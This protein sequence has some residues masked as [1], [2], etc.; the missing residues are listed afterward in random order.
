M[1]ANYV[2]LNTALMASM[3]VVG[4]GL[5][6]S[7]KILYAV[8]PD[9]TILITVIYLQICHYTFQNKQKNRP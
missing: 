6:T 9:A 7:T 3:V 2:K 5:A 8:I 4:F 1:L